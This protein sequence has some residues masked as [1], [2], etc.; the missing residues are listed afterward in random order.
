MSSF[1]ALVSYIHLVMH[2]Q[3]HKHL[4]SYIPYAVPCI[5]VCVCNYV[6]LQQSADISLKMVIL[7]IRKEVLLAQ[8]SETITI[9]IQHSIC[10][11]LV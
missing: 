6:C 7:I 4:L 5:I 3:I 8:F 11:V 1:T 9:S 10:D 2:L